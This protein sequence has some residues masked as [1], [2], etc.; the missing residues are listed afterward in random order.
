MSQSQNH[1]NFNATPWLFLLPALVMFAVYVLYPI[2]QSIALSFYEWDGLGEKTWVG[3]AN[4]VEL[5]DDD[6]FWVS[7][8]N[9][10]IWLVFFMLAPVIGLAIGTFP[11]S[12]SCGSQIGEILIF[13]PIRHLT[14]SGG[15]GI[16][17]VL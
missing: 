16:R 9:N 3:F 6:N 14:S 1:S 8:K 10:I 15:P 12:G 13:L 2:I 17:L 7:L 11:E 5:F 4:Y